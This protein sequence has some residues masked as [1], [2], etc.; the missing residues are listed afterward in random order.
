MIRKIFCSLIIALGSSIDVY[1]YA[2]RFIGDGNNLVLAIAMSIALEIFL[3]LCVLKT[4]QSKKYYILV[5]A[6]SLYAVIQTSAGQT[7]SL[8][9]S[10][11]NTG[12]T[13]IKSELI[14]EY[15][16]NLDRLEIE[17]RAINK[18]MDSVQTTAD[19]ANYGRTVYSAQL[20]LDDIS[21]ERIK[22]LQ[23]MSDLSSE[24]SKD[25]KSDNKKMSVYDFYSSM[26][27]WSSKDWLKFVF[28]TVLSLFIA[29]MTPIGILVWNA[30]HTTI[31]SIKLTD[32]DI[33]TF[34]TTA[35]YKIRQK[36]GSEILTRL[37]YDDKL[38]RENTPFNPA[39]YNVL[40]QKCVD[41]D[42]ISING[43]ANITD[44]N[45]IIRML[46]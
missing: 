32:D 39:V 12:K 28:H 3:A 9:S 27:N 33:T 38:R 19:R 45:T 29:L 30:K 40:Y 24:Y 4:T 23:S 25:E 16:K 22:S 14:E 43:Y 17:T 2:F 26:P 35:W 8:L 5:V 41:L 34:V 44:E 6:V 36:T 1:F 13:N 20:R 31:K 21:K 10:E 18:Q 11:T 7:F 46:K 15:R 37:S 42:I